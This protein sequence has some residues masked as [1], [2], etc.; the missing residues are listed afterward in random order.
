[1]WLSLSPLCSH[2]NP[3][4]PLSSH[5]QSLINEVIIPYYP[6]ISIP[7]QWSLAHDL[8]ASS[9]E[10]HGTRSG[11]LLA[12]TRRCADTGRRRLSGPLLVTLRCG[13]RRE[14]QAS[15]K[16]TARVFF[17]PNVLPNDEFLM[18]IVLMVDSG[19]SM[20]LDWSENRWYLVW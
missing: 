17:V 12:W 9:V 7:M 4:S 20:F 5:I 14:P 2:L 18:L 8:R 3:H 15:L 16:R 19:L 6:L 13:A 11:E 10:L 1:M